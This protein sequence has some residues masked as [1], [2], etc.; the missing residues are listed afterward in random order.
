[1]RLW[2]GALRSGVGLSR[3]APGL[4]AVSLALTGCTAF[5]SPGASSVEEA[6]LYAPGEPWYDQFFREVHEAQVASEG[7]PQDEAK[8]RVALAHALGAPGHTP[9]LLAEAAATRAERLAH[10]G[11]RMRLDV[12]G[13]PWRG[14]AFAHVSVQGTPEESEAVA[15][16]AIE[17]AAQDA[18]SLL[19]RLAGEADRLERLGPMGEGL[20][21]N[22]GTTF[23]KSSLSKRAE[24]KKN[25]NAA[26]ALVPILQ[27]RVR[28]TASELRRLLRELARSVKTMDG[29][30]C[31]P[32]ADAPLAPATDPAKRL[33]ARPAP[34]GRPG[35]GPRP[36]AP[37]STAPRPPGPRP[38]GPAPAP[39]EPKAPPPAAPANAPDFEP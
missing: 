12:D 26:R 30:V 24:V 13:D 32:I 14:P 16:K 25:V 8:I 29:T 39:A 17:S 4:F 11:V 7:F 27:F 23:R 22:V 19:E 28:D 10:A 2:R 1:M 35:A 38:S 20:V 9:E 3:L 36:A 21:E 6:R 33:R 37:R 15:V 18:L 31:T 34:A 5:L